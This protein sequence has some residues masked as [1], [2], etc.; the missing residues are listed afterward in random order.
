MRPDSCPLPGHR[1][2]ATDRAWVPSSDPYRSAS[3]A[4][5]EPEGK[6]TSRWTRARFLQLGEPSASGHRRKDRDRI[7][8]ADG[9]LQGAE[10]PD[11][12]FVHV[13][14][15]ETVQPAVVA[16][17]APLDPGMPSIQVLDEVANGVAVAVDG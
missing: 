16:H 5:S 10:I 13:D 15:D 7:A 17:Q 2:P 8:V 1:S 12:L 14:V 4:H 3:V 11:V 6:S 9:C